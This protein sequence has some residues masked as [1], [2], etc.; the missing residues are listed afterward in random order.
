MS[1]S[2]VAMPNDLSAVRV[3]SADPVVLHS[4]SPLLFFLQSNCWSLL[5][6][7]TCDKWTHIHHRS[8]KLSTHLDTAG[9]S[10]SFMSSPPVVVSCHCIPASTVQRTG[11][12]QAKFSCHH[13]LPLLPV[14]S[15]PVTMQLRSVTSSKKGCCF[16][17]VDQTSGWPNLAARPPVTLR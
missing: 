9:I 6:T 4:P 17:L 5:K 15:L 13:F 1:Q 2:P 10:L 14:T 12:P 8:L 7:W 3:L 16:V 11:L